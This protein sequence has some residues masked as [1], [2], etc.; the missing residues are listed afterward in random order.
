MTDRFDKAMADIAVKSAK[1]GGPTI[2]DV[3]TAMCAA[4]D[5]ANAVRDELAKTVKETAAVLH[6]EVVD[7]ARQRAVDIAESAK[8][9][10]ADLK[11]Y[12]ETQTERCAEE[13]RKLLEA[14][15]TKHSRE[16]RRKDDSED[17]NFAGTSLFPEIAFSYRFFKWLTMLAIVILLGW[18]LPFWA[19][20]CASKDLEKTSGSEPATHV[21]TPSPGVTP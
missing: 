13:H 6:A 17:V 4:H 12:R 18:G 10:E 21:L 19:D 9:V 7:A 8:L 20:S 11:G 15:F 3:L 5:D 2:Q 14:E 1:N 16:P